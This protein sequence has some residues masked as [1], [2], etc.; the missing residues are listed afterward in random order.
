M[1]IKPFAGI[2][3]PR[4]LITEVASRPYDVLNSEE[5]KAEAGEKS[6]L[7]IIKPEI[8]FDPIADEQE[9]RTYDKA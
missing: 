8:D 2:R 5:A 3:P 7:H 1:K 4:E 6:L 9:Q